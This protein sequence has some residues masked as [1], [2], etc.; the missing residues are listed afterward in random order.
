[1]TNPANRI[2]LTSPLNPCAVLR[3]A[4]EVYE[5]LVFA[6]YEHVSIRSLPGMA[7]RTLRV[8]SAG[9]T[10]SLTAW[11]VRRQLNLQA[12]GTGCERR[13]PAWYLRWH[14]RMITWG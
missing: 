4:D 1:M 6:G 14:F 12:D 8:G 9:K 5:H 3:P 11:K 7:G 13:G 2:L 10:F